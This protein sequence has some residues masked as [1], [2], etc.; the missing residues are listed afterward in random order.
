MNGVERKQRAEAGV[1]L[2]LFIYLLLAAGKLLAG[3]AAGSD[4]VKADGWNNL[5]DV[6]ASVAVYI[7]MKIAKNRAT[8]II[9][10]DIRGRRTFRRC[11]P[12]F[13]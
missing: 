9:R 2:S 8:A 11:W 1:L 10:T 6:M 3:A 4:G 7:G 13:S 12:P 5:S